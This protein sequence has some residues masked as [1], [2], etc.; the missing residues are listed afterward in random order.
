MAAKAS[1]YES[2]DA[3]IA[4]NS[5]PK[6]GPP[7]A[8]AARVL[9]DNNGNVLAVTD[10]NGNPIISAIPRFSSADSLTALAG[11]GQAGATP[12]ATSIARFT[13]VTTAG[14]SALLPVS[15]AGMEVTV[16]NAGA[17]SMN[18]FPATGEAINALAANAAF[19]VAAGKTA[20]FYCTAAGRWHTILSA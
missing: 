16:V 19:A 12:I 14:D 1:V 2:I 7:V 4:A 17:N 11:G 20:S 3:A 6:G 18:V 10:A 13:T 9:I 5:L 15:L 8:I